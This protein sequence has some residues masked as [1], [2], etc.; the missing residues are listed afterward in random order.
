MNTEEVRTRSPRETRSAHFAPPRRPRD[1]RQ[2]GTTDDYESSDGTGRA[3]SRARRAHRASP[4][5]PRRWRS[6][7]ARNR[8]VSSHPSRARRRQRRGFAPSA[9]SGQFITLSL[10]SRN[11]SIS[12]RSLTR[13]PSRRAPL[14]PQR[15]RS[16]SR[17]PPPRTPPRLSSSP[18]SKPR[19]PKR[20]ARTPPLRNRRPLLASH[21]P[22]S[23]HSVAVLEFA[24]HNRRQAGCQKR[25]FR[26]F[27]RTDVRERRV[28]SPPSL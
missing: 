5:G 26:I 28:A 23:K 3:R 4:P 18:S 22:R 24:E 9:S 14:P 25:K 7:L 1:V 10:A 15:T 20:C 2:S 6:R 12:G 16:P 27:P 11:R 13:V 19:T 21:T 8:R 17:L